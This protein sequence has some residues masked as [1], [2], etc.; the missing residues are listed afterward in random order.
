MSEVNEPTDKS[1]TGTVEWY[2]SERGVGAIKP[3]DGA[4]SYEIRSGT[5]QDCGLEALS[6]GDR[7]EFSASDEAGAR[8]ASK[9]A[10]I[11]AFDRWE[12]EGGAV[13]PAE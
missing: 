8:T 4:D 1:T 10:R 11:R 2:D 13:G 12:N 5:L 7:V 6:S 3:D 9:L